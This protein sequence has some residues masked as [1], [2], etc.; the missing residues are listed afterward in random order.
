MVGRV[1]QHTGFIKSMAIG[2]TSVLLE[3]NYVSSTKTKMV[4]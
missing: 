2:S 1:E 3:T 4:A